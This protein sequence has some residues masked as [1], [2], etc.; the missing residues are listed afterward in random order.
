MHLIEADAWIAAATGGNKAAIDIY[1]NSSGHNCMAKDA[2]N[3]DKL[4][5]GVGGKNKVTI[6][7]G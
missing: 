5:I 3:V 1:D 2:L 6:R 7:D 4:N